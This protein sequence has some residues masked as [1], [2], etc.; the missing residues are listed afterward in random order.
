MDLGSV[1]VVDLAG[2]QK[3]LATG[4]ISIQGLAWSPDAKE[5]WFTGA[6]ESGIRALYAVNLSG[7][8]RMLWRE[9]AAL[10]LHDVAPDGRVL[11]AHDSRRRGI[12][13]LAPGDKS[14]RD[15]SWLDWSISV[16]LAVD[17]K[18]LL[19]TEASAGVG[20]NYSVYLRPTGGDEAVRLGDGNALALSPDNRWALA[21]S[22][23]D[24]AQV[25]LLPTRAGQPVSLA[26]N[27]INKIAARWFADGKHLVFSGYE[28]GRAARLYVQELPAGIPRPISPEGTNAAAFTPT[29]DGRAV[30]GVG[31]DMNGYLFSVTGDEP[32]RVA[33]FEIGEL[34]IS[35]SS[36]GRFLFLYRY[37]E[38]PT[39]IQQLDAI[40][41]RRTVW[42]RLMPFDPAGVHLID[43]ILITPDLRAYAY[44][45]RRVL[46]DLFLVQGI[47]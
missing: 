19:F 9:S 4:F 1:D 3:V 24:L 45:D 5:V 20:S 30:A 31:P 43:H 18:E 35:W 42:K 47:K 29:P 2:K 39:N 8:E 14:E 33:G 36:D 12:S 16:D 21:N 32:K 37:G 27:A 6:R 41:G 40:T 26:K 46:S 10:T 13:G 15:L 44:G 23:A 34:P 17:G 38:I 25:S 11:V 7:R 28:S 22:P